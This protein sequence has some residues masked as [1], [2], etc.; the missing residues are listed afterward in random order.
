MGLFLR[1]AN[2]NNMLAPMEK[3][4]EES[5][6]F[7]LV[8]TCKYCRKYEEDADNNCTYVS[9]AIQEVDNLA[10]INADVRD[11]PTLPHEDDIECPKCSVKDAVFFQAQSHRDQVGPDAGKGHDQPLWPDMSLFMIL[12][13]AIAPSL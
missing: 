2:S 5:G 11:D 10:Q 13:C 7:K 9:R 12:R 6:E 3:N 1:H 4:N 8:Y